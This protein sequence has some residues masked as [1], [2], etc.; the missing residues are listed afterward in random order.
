MQTTNVT[1]PETGTL[2]FSADGEEI[3]EI[4]RVEPDYFQIKKG[5]IFRKEVY[6]PLSSIVGTALGG[7][8]VQVNVTKDEIEDGDWSQPPSAD[9]G[10]GTDTDLGSDVR[11]EEHNTMGAST[12][13]G[14]TGASAE[15]AASQ[16]GT[17]PA[18]AENTFGDTGSETGLRDV[19]DA[20]QKPET[21]RH[22]SEDPTVRP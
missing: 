17:P 1:P 22:W 19:T 14:T 20:S 15:M 13:Y 18:G 10:F 8:G 9:A 7:D 21:E 4:T 5:M 6:L 2:V 16:P 11:A 3:G 12:P